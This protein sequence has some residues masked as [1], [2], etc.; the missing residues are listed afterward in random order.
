MYIDYFHLSI[1][2]SLR[3][4]ISMSQFKAMIKKSCVLSLDLKFKA[5]IIKL[6]GSKTE[7]FFVRISFQASPLLFSP[8]PQKQLTHIFPYYNREKKNR[9]SF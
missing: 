4:C 7:G 8:C 1:P 9:R 2:T 5:G 6:W 3:S